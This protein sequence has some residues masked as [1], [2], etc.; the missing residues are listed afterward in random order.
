MF[1]RL[2]MKSLRPIHWTYFGIGFLCVA[3]AG[4]KLAGSNGGEVFESVDDADE[5]L[6]EDVEKRKSIEA[7]A[8]SMAYLRLPETLAIGGK[9][10]LLGLSPDELKLLHTRQ[11]QE[12]EQMLGDM[13]AVVMGSAGDGDTGISLREL[14]ALHKQQKRAPSSE[15]DGAEIVIPASEDGFPVLTVSA[16]RAMH[17]LQQQNIVSTDDAEEIV[18]PASED[19]SGGLSTVDLKGLHE[20]QRALIRKSG[21]LTKDY[22]APLPETGDPYITVEELQELHENQTIN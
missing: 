16:L 17:D 8:D 13:D 19:G 9:N 20:R 4:A 15:Y 1:K 18:V 5:N 6:I 2:V 7:R 10:D 3:I 12:I 14:R 21:D 11:Q 22:A